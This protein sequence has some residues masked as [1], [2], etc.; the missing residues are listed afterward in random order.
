MMDSIPTLLRT[1]ALLWLSATFAAAATPALRSS[2]DDAAAAGPAS[3]SPAT[4]S[5]AST[6]PASTIPDAAAP[7]EAQPESTGPAAVPSPTTAPAIS[8]PS[9]T[10]PSAPGKSSDAKGR[11]RVILQVDR[12]TEVSG[13]IQME[14]SDVLVIE[15]RTGAIHSYLKSRLFR[16]VRLI[17]DPARRPG[18]VYLKNG[19][20]RR[21]LI[22]SDEFDE[23][24]VEIEGVSATIDREVV[25]HVEL[26]P[27]WEE[28]YQSLKRS[29]DPSN[30]EGRMAVCRWLYEIGQYDVARTELLSLIT[31]SELPEARKLLNVVDAQL[32]L[33]DASAPEEVP[34][35]AEPDDIRPGRHDHLAQ[36][37]LLTQ[38]DVNL[39]RVYEIDFNDPPEIKVE[40]DT[41]RRLILQYGSSSA[42]PTGE[43]ARK[44]LFRKSSLELVR[45]MFDVKARNLYPEIRVLTEPKSLNMFR[46]RVHNAWLIP[47]CATSRCHGGPDAGGF[48]LHTRQYKDERVWMTNF[49]ILERTKFGDDRRMID[50]DVPEQSILFQYAIPRD[51]AKQP[52]PDVK[53]WSPVFNRSNKGLAED[54][55]TWI[56]TM[57][58]P[59]PEYPIDFQPPELKP[60]PTSTAPAPSGPDR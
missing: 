17:D 16:M 25:D 40:P 18:V 59:R 60:R 30:V 7:S 3:T 6:A 13:H 56:R 29:L 38:A 19:Q 43:D 9:T 53:G 20:T 39:I 42:L 47:N 55:L 10:S 21:G 58:Q 31:D 24:V 41:I 23:V 34:D 2:F 1:P 33:R 32:T 57:Y 37:K 51:Y 15:A 45:L 50:Y 52:H 44:R 26:E 48:M 46:Q 36:Q 14:D 49:L 27:S 54:T 4:T 35:E 22:I 12:H 8:T 28:R 11:S 5:P